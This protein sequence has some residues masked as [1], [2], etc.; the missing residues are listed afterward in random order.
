[1]TD[2]AHSRC[3]E[4]NFF[5]SVFKSIQII[6]AAFCLCLSVSMLQIQN[7]VHFRSDL[8]A[9]GLIALQVNPSTKSQWLVRI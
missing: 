3:S 2:L 6:I 7:E 8:I 4:M 1:M 5:L 9:V